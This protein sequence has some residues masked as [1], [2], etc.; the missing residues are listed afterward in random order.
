[1]EN[2]LFVLK[3][4]GQVLEQPEITQSVVQKFAAWPGPKILGYSS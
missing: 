3:V 1:M 2:T 4:G